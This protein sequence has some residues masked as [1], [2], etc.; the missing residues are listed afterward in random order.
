MTAD[1]LRKAEARYQR[2]SRRSEELRLERNRLIHEA[3][4]V[5]WT[6]ARIAEATGMTR[7]RVG[8]IAQPSDSLAWRARG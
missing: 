6:H 2:A 4:A 5:G 3:L 7:G 8:Q 1:E